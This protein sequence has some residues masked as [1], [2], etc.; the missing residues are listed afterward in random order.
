MSTAKREKGVDEMSIFDDLGKKLSKAGGNAV[1]KT[2]Q[3]TEIARINGRIKDEKK[4]IDE[5][6]RIIGEMFVEAFRDEAPEEFEVYIRQIDES[7]E[8]IEKYKEDIDRVKGVKKCPVCGKELL[9]QDHFCS[10]CGAD[11]E[12]AVKEAEHA[13]RFDE[14]SE[15]ATCPDCGAI[16]KA[17]AEVCP[18]CGVRFDR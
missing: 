6:H 3:R 17:G 11:F 9:A 16:I 2:K 12:E 15:V 13:A 1:E 14:D 10:E 4:K 8:N 18:A 5:S 7:N